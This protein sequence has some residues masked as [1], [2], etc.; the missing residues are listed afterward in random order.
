M[1]E[2]PIG[3]GMGLTAEN[4]AER[5][6]ISRKDQDELALTSHTRA[7]EAIRKGHFND[8]ITPVE[9]HGRKGEMGIFDTD[10]HPREG[11]TKEK[12][13]TLPA[14]FKEG[15]TVTAGSS[16][17]I[18]DGAAAVVLMSGEKV[19]ELGIKPMAQLLG[20]TVV[21]VDP[22][23]MGDGPVPATKKVLRKTGLTLKDIDLVELNEAFAAQYLSCERALGLDREI[24]NVNG[25]GIALGHPVGSTGCRLIVTLIYEMKKRDVDLGLATLCAGGGQ[26]FGMVV[27]NL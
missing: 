13:A 3:A 19:K 9:I 22:N 2:Y 21:G 24:T 1:Q 14:A 25:S 15:G 11:L 8:E 18:N 23:Y 6:R 27:E 5:D 16:S 17:G 10:E 4:V 12:L 20:A 7:V 26:G